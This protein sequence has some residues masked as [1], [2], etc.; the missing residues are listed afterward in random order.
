M[1]DIPID[2]YEDGDPLRD[3]QSLDDIE[4]PEDQDVAD[5]YLRLAARY[6]HEARRISDQFDAEIERLV[7]R[8]DDLMRAPVRAAER[9]ADLVEGWAVAN[10]TEHRKSFALPSGTVRTFAGRERI[11]VDDDAAVVDWWEQDKS[12]PVCV[13]PDPKVHK[14]SI[15]ASI[16]SKV[17][18]VSDD[19]GV[20]VA[21]TGEVVPGVRVVVGDSTASIVGD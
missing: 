13:Q 8:R 9:F 10:R 21:A 17:L 4:P 2:L 19:G 7:A 5:R 15:K 16:D 3:G 18:V 12:I 14:P 11:E 6:K 1:T 20:T